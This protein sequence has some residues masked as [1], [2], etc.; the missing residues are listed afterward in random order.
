MRERMER[1]S[2]CV[3]SGRVRVSRFSAS[4][5]A[6]SGLAAKADD[7]T[8]SASPWAATTPHAPRLGCLSSSD[9]PFD[10]LLLAHLFSVRSIAG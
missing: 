5:G 9:S 3:Q 6:C 4:F 10:R 7:E 8:Q 1:R 2:V